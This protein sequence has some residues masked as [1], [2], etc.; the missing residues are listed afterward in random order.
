[1]SISISRF[2]R[3]LTPRSTLENQEEETSPAQAQAVSGSKRV[4]GAWLRKALKT[5]F[6]W[7][8]R[9]PSDEMVTPH[10]RSEL[11]CSRKQ[12]L[13]DFKTIRPLGEGSFG[14]VLLCRERASKE[15]YAM[16]VLTRQVRIPDFKHAK[17]LLILSTLTRVEVRMSFV[18]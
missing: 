4:R 6:S 3:Y 5:P 12:K 17:P 18:R 14:K 9:L 8:S 10:F 1:M 16:K 2:P 11:N 13:S 7:C 15:L